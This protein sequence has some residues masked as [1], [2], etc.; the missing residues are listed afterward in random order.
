MSNPNHAQAALEE[1]C[2]E[3]LRDLTGAYLAA[4]ATDF[5]DVKARAMTAAL[6]RGVAHADAARFIEDGWPKVLTRFQERLKKL[7]VY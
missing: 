6:R 5:K 2:H 4:Q 1:C 3:A 7:G